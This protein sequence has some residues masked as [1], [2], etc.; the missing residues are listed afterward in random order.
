[1]SP[2]ISKNLSRIVGIIFHYPAPRKPVLRPRL[3]LRTRVLS[4][5]SN[6]D[7]ERVSYSA[8]WAPISLPRASSAGASVTPCSDLTKVEQAQYT[9][10]GQLPHAALP[11]QPPILMHPQFFVSNLQAKQPIQTHYTQIPAFYTSSHPEQHIPV[12]GP[13]FT[14][15]PPPNAPELPFARPEPASYLTAFQQHPSEQMDIVGH[16]QLIPEPLQKPQ[17]QDHSAFSALESTPHVFTS[18]YLQDQH[19]F[20]QFFDAPQAQF[21]NSPP[22]SSLPHCSFSHSSP[23]VEYMSTPPSISHQ[24]VRPPPSY[25]PGIMAPTSQSHVTQPVQDHNAETFAFNVLP[26]TATPHIDFS[27]H[28]TPT[29]PPYSDSPESTPTREVLLDDGPMW[30]PASSEHAPAQPLDPKPLEPSPSPLHLPEVMPQPSSPADS[31]R[32]I[33]EI[34]MSGASPDIADARIDSW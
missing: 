24:Q 11:S 10:N 22:G 25:E 20:T 3:D 26:D 18:S 17:A 34:T 6:V 1:M 19:A 7:F 4:S 8:S 9:E 14:F 33:G 31:V 29:R 30:Q 23:V 2:P 32:A 13:Q 21:S 12:Y 15:P 27:C 16:R 28:P 5:R